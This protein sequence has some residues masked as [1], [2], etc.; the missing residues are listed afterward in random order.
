MRVIKAMQ[1]IRRHFSQSSLG[2]GIAGTGIA[3]PG[4]TPGGTGIV[5]PGGTG[6]PILPSGKPGI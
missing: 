6:V 5:V 2:A 4:A 1:H 3:A